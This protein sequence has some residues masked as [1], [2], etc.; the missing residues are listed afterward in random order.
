MKA[1]RSLRLES[2]AAG[3]LGLR[4]RMPPG[5]WMSLCCECCVC[6]Q[7]GVSAT[8]NPSSRGVVCLMV[9]EEPRR[10]GLWPV[11]LSSHEKQK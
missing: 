6:C 1:N 8:A 5:A 11:E 9:V 3:L 10:G 4:V 7:V 2:A